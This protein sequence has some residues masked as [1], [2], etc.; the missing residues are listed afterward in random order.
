MFDFKKNGKRFTKHIEKE[1]SGEIDKIRICTMFDC[2][3][4]PDSL[5]YAHPCIFL[6]DEGVQGIQEHKCGECTTDAKVI[7]VRLDTLECLNDKNSEW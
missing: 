1:F 2:K 7:I 5:G 4:M 6:K 3:E